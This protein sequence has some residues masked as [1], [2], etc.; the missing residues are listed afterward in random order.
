MADA[1]A[2]IVPNSVGRGVASTSDDRRAA[3]RRTCRNDDRPCQPARRTGSKTARKAAHQDS[4]AFL[5]GPTPIAP[6][7]EGMIH[8]APSVGGIQGI[9]IDPLESPARDGGA[10][11]FGNS[12]R[13]PVAVRSRSRLSP[14]TSA[15]TGPLA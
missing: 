1:P 15:W 2:T 14:T 6:G 5:D 12:L 9:R 10:K 11:P 3:S 4:Q 8:L 13:V 7:A